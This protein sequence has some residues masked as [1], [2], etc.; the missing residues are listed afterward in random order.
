MDNQLWVLDF[1]LFR[2]FL[3]EVIFY[4]DFLDVQVDV[5]VSPEMKKTL[6]CFP[7]DYIV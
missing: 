1:L 2:M 3:D 6:D 7:T 4:R 5:F